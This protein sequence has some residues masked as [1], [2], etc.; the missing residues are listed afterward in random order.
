MTQCT[1]T[2]QPVLRRSRAG[3]AKAGTYAKR[4]GRGACQVCGKLV[5]CHKDGTAVYHESAR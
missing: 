2:R 3:L 5:T 4:Y 1:G